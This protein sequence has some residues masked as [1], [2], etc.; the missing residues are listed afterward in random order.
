MQGLEIYNANSSLEFTTSTRL[1]RHLVTFALGNSAG[2]RFVDGLNTGTPVAIPNINTGT[3]SFVI[4]QPP[5]FTFNTTN[6]TI[7]WSTPAP[8]GTCIVTI[9]VY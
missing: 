9:F 6:Q 1:S 7:S 3:S 2:S 5:T 4:P 8:A